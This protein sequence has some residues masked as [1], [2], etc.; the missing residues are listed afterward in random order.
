[1]KIRNIIFSF[2]LLLLISCASIIKYP[3][4]TEGSKADAIVTVTY[5]YPSGENPNDWQEEWDGIDASAVERC[6]NWG[7]SDAIKFDTGKRWCLVF[8]GYGT[9]T[10]WQENLNYQCID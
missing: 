1:M 2:S 7:Y 10:Y 6:Q 8:N 5:E 4:A 9:C 3:A